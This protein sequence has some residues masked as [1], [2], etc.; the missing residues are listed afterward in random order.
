MPPSNLSPYPTS[1]PFLWNKLPSISSPQFLFSPLKYA[2]NKL[3]LL[4]P[5]QL[6]LSEINSHRFLPLISC[7]TFAIHKLYSLFLLWNK[8]WYIWYSVSLNSIHLTSMSIFPNFFPIE[9]DFSLASPSHWFLHRIKTYLYLN[10]GLWIG[11]GPDLQLRLD[12]DVAPDNSNLI[13]LMTFMLN[14]TLSLSFT[15]PLSLHTSSIHTFSHWLFYWI[16][17]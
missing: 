11:A 9:I 1:T 6:L 10:L 16:L 4:I 15:L 7:S 8:L 12:L 2:P 5:P 13:F 3:Q 14:M 17:H